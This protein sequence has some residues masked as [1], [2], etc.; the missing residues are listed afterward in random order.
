MILTTD[1]RYCRSESQLDQE[2]LLGA[3]GNSPE[4]AGLEAPVWQGREV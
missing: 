3:D 1:D 2:G 4:R